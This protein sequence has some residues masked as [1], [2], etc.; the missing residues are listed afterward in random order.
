MAPAC[1]HGD[2]VDAAGRV[3]VTFPND[4]VGRPAVYFSLSQ[5]ILLKSVFPGNTMLGAGAVSINSSSSSSRKCRLC[6]VPF[7]PRSSRSNARPGATSAIIPQCPPRRR[8]DPISMSDGTG[9]YVGRM[10]GI[11]TLAPMLVSAGRNSG[12]FSFQRLP[13]RNPRR[14][15][16]APVPRHPREPSKNA[17][18]R[19]PRRRRQGD[20]SSTITPNIGADL[21]TGLSLCFHNPGRKWFRLRPSLRPRSWRR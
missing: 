4:V 15:K 20:K 19:W 18:A 6:S 2:Q 14:S 13:N 7:H 5:A 11:S 9:A 1:T 8:T 17:A 21:F 16:S 10:Y 12:L 3:I